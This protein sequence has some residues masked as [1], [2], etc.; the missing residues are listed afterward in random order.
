MG[1]GGSG[2]SVPNPTDFPFDI[3]APWGSEQI[4]FSSFQAGEDEYLNCA[5]T[6]VRKFGMTVDE[7]TVEY[8]G[9]QL[10][11]SVD[12]WVGVS[13]SNCLYAGATAGAATSCSPVACYS[14]PGFVG[15]LMDAKNYIEDTA[16]DVYTWMY[17]NIPNLPSPS[18]TGGTAIILVIAAIV[19]IALIIPGPQPI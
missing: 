16:T 17:Q 10:T 5:N 15:A 8:D 2:L 9:L 7:Y 3:C 12:V 4:C 11:N 14:W 1:G 13:E 6:T 19:G 18:S